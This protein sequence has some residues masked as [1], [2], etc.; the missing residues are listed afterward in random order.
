MS[1][2][3]FM[4]LIRSLQIINHKQTNIKAINITYA[5]NV[6]NNIQTSLA[7][8]YTRFLQLR[9]TASCQ[10]RLKAIG[11]S[12]SEIAAVLQ[13]QCNAIVALRIRRGMQ[14]LQFYDQLGYRMNTIKSSLETLKSFKHKRKPIGILFSALLFDWENNKI[15]NKDIDTLILKYNIELLFKFSNLVIHLINATYL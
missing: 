4:K 11:K 15:T 9:F 13:K 12:C 8:R 10:V 2:N 14:I 3:T 7:Y 5:R 6:S 1:H